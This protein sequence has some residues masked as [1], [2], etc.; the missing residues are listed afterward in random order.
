M[1]DC[2]ITFHQVFITRVGH[3][4]QTVRGAT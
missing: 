2:I 1:P 4:C 3:S